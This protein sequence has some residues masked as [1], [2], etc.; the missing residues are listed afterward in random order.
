MQW[1][2]QHP[3]HIAGQQGHG[4]GYVKQ[5]GGDGELSNAAQTP[6]EEDDGKGYEKIGE[7][8][9][10]F[11]HGVHFLLIWQPFVEGRDGTSKYLSTLSPKA[12]KIPAPL[13]GKICNHFPRQAYIEVKSKCGEKIQG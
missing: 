9:S 13:E 12:G 1:N 3:G 11:P 5:D 4:Y 10:V 8:V 2:V 7:F 6:D